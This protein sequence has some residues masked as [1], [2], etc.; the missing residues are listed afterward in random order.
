MPQRISDHTVGELSE[1]IPGEAKT[2]SVFE[3]ACAFPTY[4]ILNAHISSSFTIG[5]LIAVATSNIVGSFGCAGCEVVSNK[6]LAISILVSA[7][8]TMIIQSKGLYGTAENKMHKLVLDK[9]LPRTLAVS[10]AILGAAAVIAQL[11]PMVDVDAQ[12]TAITY[13]V[14]IGALVPAIFLTFV[15][16]FLAKMA[17]DK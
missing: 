10:V 14:G 4:E 11:N 1:L 5:I 8:L 12:D 2:G 17:R 15:E 9:F 3:L 13:W 16:S 7:I 6:S